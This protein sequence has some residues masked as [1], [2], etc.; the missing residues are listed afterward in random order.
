ME[1]C[2]RHIVAA[3]FELLLEVSVREIKADGYK[4]EEVSK[5]EYIKEYLEEIIRNSVNMRNFNS[6]RAWY[7]FEKAEKLEAKACELEEK[8]GE[9]YDDYRQAACFLRCDADMAD[10]EYLLRMKHK[11]L[12]KK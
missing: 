9:C 11:Q 5:P 12:I 6:L 8:T 4:I 1:F 2:H 3:W 10:D 7:L